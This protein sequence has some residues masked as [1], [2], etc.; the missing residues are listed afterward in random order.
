MQNDSGLYSAFYKS[1]IIRNIDKIRRNLR[2]LIK[3]EAP[4][5]QLK[6]KKIEEMLLN[7]R[8]FIRR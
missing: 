5:Q 1:V 6:Y 8:N 2:S 4:D 3:V 7:I